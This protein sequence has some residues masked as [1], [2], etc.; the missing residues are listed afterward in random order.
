MQKRMKLSDMSIDTM[1]ELTK[2]IL[3]ITKN[4][5][6]AMAQNHALILKLEATAGK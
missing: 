4:E 3:N 1:A 2:R 5:N 6:Y